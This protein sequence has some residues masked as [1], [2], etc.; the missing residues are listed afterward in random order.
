[1]C[2]NRKVEHF[3]CRSYV[4]LEAHFLFQRPLT[5]MLMDWEL[6]RFRLAGEDP[7]NVSRLNISSLR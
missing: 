3:V 5:V 7:S 1:M 4:F 6:P 2:A